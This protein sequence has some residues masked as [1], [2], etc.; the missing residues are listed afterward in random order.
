MADAEPLAGR[1]LAAFVAAVEAGSVQGAADAL[2]LTQSGATKR[3]QSLERRLGV[4]LLE[5]TRRGV[6]P[7]AAGQRLYPAAKQALAVLAR[8]EQA[9]AADAPPLRLASSHT[10]GEF[11][12]PGWLSR[13]AATAAGVTPELVIVNSHEVAHR[14]RTNAADIGFVEGR[15]DDRGL[16]TLLLDRDEIVG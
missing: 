3:L 4:A 10:I 6:V 2:Q 1:D 14:V 9:V 13:F 8:A 7:T 16:A 15:A 12:L 5:R 11:L